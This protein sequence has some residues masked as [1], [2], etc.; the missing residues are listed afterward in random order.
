ME[1]GSLPVLY[2]YH[3]K[4]IEC[5]QNE[6][7]CLK[8]LILNIAEEGCSCERPEVSV[9]GRNIINKFGTLCLYLFCRNKNDSMTSVK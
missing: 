6:A 4:G 1:N 7:D 3:F 8:A 5:N 2:M 9:N